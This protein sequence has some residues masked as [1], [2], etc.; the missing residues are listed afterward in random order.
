MHEYTIKSAEDK[1]TLIATSPLSL[2][3][4]DLAPANIL[5]GNPDGP[6]FH[7]TVDLKYPWIQVTL[8]KEVWVKGV[9]L[10]GR[11]DVHRQE[12]YEVKKV[13]YI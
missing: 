6:V 13:R 4:A 9:K 10:H 7:P 1:S 11:P 3:R 5:D 2:Y 12:F 8:P